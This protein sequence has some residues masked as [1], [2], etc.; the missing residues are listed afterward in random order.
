MAVI[1]GIHGG[2]TR[3]LHLLNSAYMVLIPK[4][5]EPTGVGDYRPISLVHSVAKLITKILAN[6]L[7]PKM[8][9]IIASN[10]SAFIR[11]RRIHD[12]FLQVQHMAK[13][14]HNQRKPRLMIKLDITEAFDSVS[15]PFL[16]EVLTHLGFGH[17]WRQLI[18]SLLSSSSTRVLLNGH[19]GEPI[20]H[21]RGLR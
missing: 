5:E 14:L 20:R 3:K 8:Q 12:N 7:A 15:W 2:D 11:G 1:G 21:R 16:L 4:K 13:Y 19:P 6:R 9:D 18:C 17:R 10:Q